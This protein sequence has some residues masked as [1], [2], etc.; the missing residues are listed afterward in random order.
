MVLQ[1]THVSYSF[2]SLLPVRESL[3]SRGGRLQDTLHQRQN[4]VYAPDV[5]VQI[6]VEDAA[7]RLSV[8]FSDD[9]RLVLYHG[10]CR[11]MRIWFSNIGTREIGD[12][13]LVSGQED[14]LW[15]EEAGDKLAGM[16]Q[17]SLLPACRAQ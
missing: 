5:V 6:E 12:I 16:H 11:Q 10:E 2:L 13:W 1:V 7:Q 8:E 4:K 9:S 17:V 3:V 15:V 14:E